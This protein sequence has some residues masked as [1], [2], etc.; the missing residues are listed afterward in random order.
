MFTVSVLCNEYDCVC[1]SSLKDY[2]LTYCDCT[3]RTQRAVRGAR[4]RTRRS[5]RPAARL[6][7]QRRHQSNTYSINTLE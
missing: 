5:R 2:L 1:P 4:Q 3:A 7:A 6:H